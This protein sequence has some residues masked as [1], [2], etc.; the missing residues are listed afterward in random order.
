[1]KQTQAKYWLNGVLDRIEKKYPDGEIIV[2]SGISPSAEYHIG[3]FREILS[4]DMIK[5][6]LE[7]RGRTVRHLHVVDN[8]DPL[9]KRYDFLPEEYEKYVGWPVC[10]VPDPDA[11][12]ENYAQHFFDIFKKYIE[13]LNLDVEIVYSY[14]DLYKSG[15]MASQIEKAIENKDKI[16]E[17][18]AR[19]SN[20]QLPEDWAP[21]QILSDDN[22]FDDWQ[23]RDID[24]DKK[25]I[26]YVDKQGNEGWVKYD[27]GRVKLNWRLDWPARWQ[28]LGVM[29]EPHGFQEHGASGGS[30]QTGQI[31]AR[32]VYDFEGPLAGMQYGHVHLV[33]DNVKM[34]SSKGNLVTP[35][36]AFKIMPP[37]MMKY[38][39]LRYPGKKRIDFDPGLGLY[40]M[41]DEYSQVDR[42]VRGGKDNQFSPAYTLANNGVTTHG[43]SSVPFNH[44]V[45]MYQAALGDKEKI[46]EILERSGYG[47]EVSEQKNEIESELQYVENW[48]E[49]WAPDE[50]KFSLSEN[51][52]TDL[53]HNEKQ[54]LLDLAD[55][56]ESD[57]KTHDGQWYHEQ[58]HEV[59]EKSGL[60]AGEAFKTVYKT[61]LGQDSGPK[62]GWFL[63]ILDKNFVIERFRLDA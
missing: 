23:Y 19:V 35:E 46:F 7:N 36:Q 1:M 56:F 38:F 9:R 53:S 8:F 52:P 57:D 4:A 55:V 20:R 39:Y 34:S 16:R 41:M 24:T 61:L 33:G 51:P 11:C 5:V 47:T 18:F 3:H 63:S 30:F 21:I 62:A 22:N 10:L 31:F 2:S 40:R 43:M 37:E 49:K 60:G 17:V 27:D 48:L 58:I 14:E 28:V 13:Q 26:K 25:Q 54:F 32:N 29:V 50:V 6:G 59:R 45:S 12:H 15:R 42:D 44:L